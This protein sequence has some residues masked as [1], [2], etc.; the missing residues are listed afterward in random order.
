M[1]RILEWFWRLLPDKCQMPGCERMGVRGNENRV[2]GMILCDYC[3]SKA[4]YDQRPWPLR[5]TNTAA[6]H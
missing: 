5:A 4:M 6:T 2:D 3:H 1:N